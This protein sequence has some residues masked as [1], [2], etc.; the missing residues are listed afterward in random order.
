MIIH[1]GPRL[2]QD[3]GRIVQGTEKYNGRIVQRTENTMDASSKSENTMV[4]TSKGQKDNGRII[5][6]TENTMD[7]SSKGQKIQGTHRPR[8]RKYNGRI[9]QGKRS[10]TPWLGTIVMASLSGFLQSLSFITTP[11]T[12]LYVQHFTWTSK[13][14]STNS[15]QAKILIC[16][17]N[18]MAGI[19]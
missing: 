11:C 17:R 1:C 19:Y 4:A 14:N 6:G 16:K 10:G 3:Q 15:S 7:A 8:D 13:L 12:V 5:Q 9:V 18:R 2:G